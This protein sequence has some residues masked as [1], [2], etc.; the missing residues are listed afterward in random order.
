MMSE[1]HA[2]VVY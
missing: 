1:M 2:C